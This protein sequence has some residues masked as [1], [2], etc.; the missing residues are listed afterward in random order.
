MAGTKKPK[1][2]KDGNGKVLDQARGNWIPRDE[3]TA[4][5]IENY[6]KLQQNLRQLIAVKEAALKNAERAIW[7]IQRTQGALEQLSR[8]AK[9]L[10]IDLQEELSKRKKNHE[11]KKPAVKASD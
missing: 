1:P 8:T 2:A 5:M 6:A 11:E 7:G 9:S 3:L 10:G 4:E